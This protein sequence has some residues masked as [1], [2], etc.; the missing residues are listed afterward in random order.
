MVALVPLVI[1]HHRDAQDPDFV[2]AGGAF[3]LSFAA[4]AV[5]ALAARIVHLVGDGARRGCGTGTDRHDRRPPH[6]NADEMR[7]LATP[8]P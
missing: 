6:H 1:A 7:D 4:A 8:S 3:G 2:A 5:L